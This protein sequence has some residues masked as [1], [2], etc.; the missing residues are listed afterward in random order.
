MIKVSK[1]QILEG[2]KRQ[3]SLD[4]EN[5]LHANE[6]TEIEIP[7]LRPAHVVEV[8]EDLDKRGIIEF[9]DL[10]EFDKNGWQWDYWMELQINEKPYTLK[11][12]GYYHNCCTLSESSRTEN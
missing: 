8:L 10:N 9:K 12:D 5:M 7:F 2:L 4:I 3:T 1:E 11:G 6:V